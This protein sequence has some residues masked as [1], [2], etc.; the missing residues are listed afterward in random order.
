ATGHGKQGIQ[1]R[2]SSVRTKALGD[3]AKGQRMGQHLVIPG[4]V[5]DRQQRDTGILLQLPVASPQLAA[6]GAQ[7]SF[8]QLTLPVSLKRFLQ[9]TVAADPRESQG[10]GECHGCLQSINEW[11]AVWRHSKRETNSFIFYTT[12]ITLTLYP[13]RPSSGGR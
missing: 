4:E 5:T 3:H 12:Q 8:I 10:V 6:N 9:F 11:R 13:V 2:P 7:A 1:R